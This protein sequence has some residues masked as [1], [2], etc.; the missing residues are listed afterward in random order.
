MALSRDEKAEMLRR[1]ELFAVLPPD[2]LAA[3]ADEAVEVQFP[4]GRPIVRQGEVGTGLF[5]L[6]S[7]RARVVRDGDQIAELG[8]GDTLAALNLALHDSSPRVRT[9][10]IQTAGRLGLDAKLPVVR[11]AVTDPDS[12]S[13]ARRRRAAP[14]LMSFWLAETRR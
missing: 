4:A 2:V 3:A 1:V 10:A 6:T 12:T 9:F 13:T 14:S 5:V 7:G 8:P 11:A